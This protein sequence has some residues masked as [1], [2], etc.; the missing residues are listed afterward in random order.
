MFRG[1][2]SMNLRLFDIS[3]VLP[4]PVIFVRVHGSCFRRSILWSALSI[5][6]GG[7]MSGKGS[8]NLRL[9]DID[10]LDISCN[11]AAG[12]GKAIAGGA[13]LTTILVAGQFPVVVYNNNDDQ[14]S[15]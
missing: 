8:T 2:G 10:E 12:E 14:C 15:I 7:G 4:C 3:S 11:V 1:K 6:G 9:F 13:T 5:F